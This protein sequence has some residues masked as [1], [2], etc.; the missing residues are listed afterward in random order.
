[1]S[2]VSPAPDR[3]PPRLGLSRSDQVV[4][5]GIAIVA[6]AA[7]VG[8]WL[9]H[10]GWQG[11]LVE[12]DDAPP[13]AVEFQVD[14]NS[15]DWAELAQMPGIG[16]ALGRRIVESRESQGPFKRPEDIRRVRGIGVKTDA[17]I[18]PELRDGSGGRR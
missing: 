7:M 5:A 4:V 9:S 12:I 14:L 11:E 2:N 6:L 1:M 13:L 10:G 18:R 16:P 17:R 8:W 15:A 3:G